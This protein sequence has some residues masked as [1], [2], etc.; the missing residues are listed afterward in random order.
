MKKKIVV[1]GWIL[2][3]VLAVSLF[4]IAVMGVLQGE[5]TRSWKLVRG[6]RGGTVF[7]VE[8]LIFFLAA[9]GIGFFWIKRRFFS[10]KRE[11]LKRNM[12]KSTKS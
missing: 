1:I 12:D 2:I 10:S 6:G 9:I 5:G 8:L 7:P 4:I 3:G 11:D